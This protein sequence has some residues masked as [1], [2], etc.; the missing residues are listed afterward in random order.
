[1][2]T[3]PRRLGAGG[4]KRIAPPLALGVFAAITL[5]ATVVALVSRAAAIAVPCES[6]ECAFPRL[7]AFG[8]WVVLFGGIFVYSSF[9][10]GGAPN[11]GWFGY[12]PLTS[13]PMSL[14]VH[15]TPCTT[16]V[17]A[18]RKPRCRR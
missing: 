12:T 3:H 8:Y 15:C 2:T 7:N 11:G 16:T 18:S 4:W 13:S 9:F 5:A 6:A 10:L 17:D 1:M 14:G